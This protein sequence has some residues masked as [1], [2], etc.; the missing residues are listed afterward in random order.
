MN[1]PT[2][3]DGRP[4][5]G[6]RVGVT[7]HRPRAGLDLH[8]V[9]DLVDRVLADIDAIVRDLAGQPAAAD[10][11]SAQEPVVQVLSSLAEGADRLGAEL[12]VE[13]RWRLVAPLPFP[14]AEYER[15]FPHSVQQF[16]ALLA[17]AD[18]DGAV[19]QLD[20]SR[21]A[22]DDAYLQ[23]GR[24]LV[25]NSDLLLAVWDGAP[26]A[27]TGGTGQI[28]NEA[29]AA[30]IPVVHVAT[31]TRPEVW[32]LLS[33]TDSVTYDRLRL[34]QVLRPALLPDWP[35]GDPD[36]QAG[37]S[38]YLCREAVGHRDV[39][40][41]YLE[42]GPFTAPRSRVAGVFPWLKG[43]LAR[44][45]GAHGEVD[46]LPPPRKAGSATARALFLHFQRADTLA[47]FYANLH[48]SVFVLIYMFGSL[49]LVAAFLAL[50]FA[51][52]SEA[53]RSD[54]SPWE[55]GFAALELL[56]VSAIFMLVW[57]DHRRHWRERWLNYRLLAELL[58]QADILACL[59]GAPLTG[60]LD[61]L[62]ETHPERGWVPWLAGAIIRSAGVI[63]TT[64]DE[65]YLTELRDYVVRR[66]LAHQIAYHERTSEQ[67][68][69]VNGA[70]RGFS[71]AMFALT[72][73]AILVELFGRRWGGLLAGVFPALGA[74]GFGI[75]SQ[76]EFEIVVRRSSR[77]RDLLK[78]E[79][80][81]IAALTGK[82][83]TGAALAAAVQRVA[84]VM[85]SDSAQWAGIFEVKASEVV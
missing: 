23:A 30:G 12:A 15:D 20:G 32:L 75:R 46:Q 29:Q 83:L 63:G 49:A 42:Q 41:D 9:K 51:P 70:L 74:A 35:A 81:R 24:F 37:A 69:A 45:R 28:V 26:P 39:V 59:G 33:G 3:K 82:Q 84:R 48:R 76:A 52:P 27:G 25:R 43:L 5:F 80:E 57:F 44:N 50:F 55:L 18:R 47:T 22:A 16:E 6:L 1:E 56:L 31:G 79:S 11:Y 71:V 66:R 2:A 62:G 78:W 67:N 7:G 21:A 17:Q 40:L 4:A 38:Q 10:F 68:A 85:Q 58:R 36:N 72:F 34:E 77:Q 61:R 73:C 8:A 19:V 13:R 53:P 14:R 54:D 64:Y 60:V 65:P